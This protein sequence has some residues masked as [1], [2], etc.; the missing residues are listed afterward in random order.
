MS[1]PLSTLTLADRL[2]GLSSDV[3]LEAAEAWRLKR[4]WLEWLAQ[5][6]AMLAGLAAQFAAGT[7]SMLP[8]QAARSAP[9]HPRFKAANAPQPGR[10]QVYADFTETEF[11]AEVP[12]TGS[13]SPEQGAPATMGAS[14]ST[15][16]A[17]AASQPRLG[18]R[19]DRR[20]PRRNEYRDQASPHAY[21][22]LKT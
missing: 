1:A 11:P 10:A 8:P 15:G 4:L 2:A 17:R 13:F 19:P 21:F 22:V 14:A 20:P 12:A 18:S 6:L 5:I 16:P 9:M 7:L 3:G